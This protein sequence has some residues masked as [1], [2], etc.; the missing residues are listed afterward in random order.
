M[1]HAPLFSA[2]EYSAMTMEAWKRSPLYARTST[3]ACAARRLLLRGQ[4]EEIRLMGKAETPSYIYDE[5]AQ[6]QLERYAARAEALAQ[7]LQETRALLTAMVNEDVMRELPE[8]LQ[9]K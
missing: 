3:T 9:M 7:E 2:E 1:N 4:M 8:G 5:L 6:L